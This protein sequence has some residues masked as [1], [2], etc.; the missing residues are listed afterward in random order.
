MLIPFSGLSVWV[1]SPKIVA[2]HLGSV[3]VM[4]ITAIAVFELFE[5]GTASAVTTAQATSPLPAAAAVAVLLP[6]SLE[7]GEVVAA[8]VVVGGVL[9]ALSDSFGQLSARRANVV[10]ATASIGGGLLTVLSGSMAAEGV[11]VVEVYSV[12]TAL[13]AAIFMAAIPPRDIPRSV[14]PLLIVRSAFVSAGFALTILGVQIGSPTVLQAMLALI[15]LFVLSWEM[16]RCHRPP[17]RR[18]LTAALLALLGVLM[19]VLV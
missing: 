11:G 17:S 1:W 16:L 13:A 5:H 18:L 7:W 6:T 14:L 3:V 4:A 9:W 2:L 15:P 8:I 10:V 19:T 12:R